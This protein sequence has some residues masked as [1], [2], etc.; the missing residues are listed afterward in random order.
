ML[1]AKK[2]KSLIY[3]FLKRIFHT[4]PMFVIRFYSRLYLIW[5]R[6]RGF[7]LRINMY[8]GRSREGDHILKLIYLGWNDQVISYFLSFFFTDYS[9]LPS[10]KKILP[11]NL[12]EYVD[13][14]QRNGALILVE[15]SNRSVRRHL[16]NVS[17]F[18]LPRWLK[19][20]IDVDFSLSQN[21]RINDILRLIKKHSLGYEISDKVEDFDFFYYR[22]Y[23]PYVL[24]R[25]GGSAV[26]ENYKPMRED[27][28]NYRS[29]LYFITRE[30]SRVAC[31]Y[32]RYYDN[33]PYIYALGIIDGSEEVMRMGVI[34]AMYYFVLENHMKNNIKTLK[35]GGTSPFLNDGLTF[36]KLSLGAKVLDL[37][38]QDSLK[39]QL[40][41]PDTASAQKFLTANPFIFIEKD[42]IYC[43]VFRDDNDPEA[44]PKT[45]RILAHAENLEVDGIRILKFNADHTI[46][47]EMISRYNVKTI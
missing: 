4:S 30:G 34:G 1:S 19:M 27:F 28:S 22:M 46:S 26:V 37:E 41:H 47:T 11:W 23:S 17:G 33:T 8:E 13:E 44:G 18:V 36:F 39:L 31:I 15:M 10:G 25:H 45:Q 40:I 43:A 35:I 24:G 29:L 32:E 12:K 20:Y 14:Q 6:I 2:S 9:T 42:K 38:F 7:W 16:K 5:S 3:G 21:K